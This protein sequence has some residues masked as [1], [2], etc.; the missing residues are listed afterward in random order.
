MKKIL[1]FLITVGFISCKDS[2]DLPVNLPTTGYLVVDGTI[3]SGN[4][5]TVINLSRTQKLIDSFNIRYENNANV[6]VEG[7]DNSLAQLS[8]QGNGRYV[9]DQLNL[10]RAL[11]YRLRILTTANQ[12]YVSEFMPVK[13]SPAIDNITW[14][15]DEEGVHIFANAKG[16]NN[17]S[18]YYRWDYE[19]DWEFNSAYAPSLM[20]NSVPLAVFIRRDQSPDFSRYTCYQHANSTTIEILSTA[21]LSRDTTHYRLALVPSGSWKISVLYA[22]K[23]RQYSISRDGYEYLARM[24]KNTEQTGSIFDSQ[25][26]ELK[27][28]ISCVSEPAEPVIGFMEISDMYSERIFIKASEVPAW[29]YSHGCFR[30]LFV[31]NPDSIKYYGFPTPVGPDELTMTG[32]VATYFATDLSC[33]DCTMRGN[34]AKPDFWP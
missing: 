30:N 13:E 34:L 12:E 27:G 5:E 28:N 22:I 4:G 31:N 2:Y 23:V 3:N 20:Y 29:G 10:N 21:K 7:E 6:I 15:R 11:K 1:F 9:A 32:D 26:S 33:I 18:G 17:T 25:P 14:E 24:R 8:F 19:E 16:S